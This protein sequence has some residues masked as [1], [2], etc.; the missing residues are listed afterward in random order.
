MGFTAAAGKFIVSLFVVVLVIPIAILGIDWVLRKGLP[1]EPTLTQYPGSNNSKELFV[2]LPGAQVSGTPLFVQLRLPLQ[3]RGDVLVVDYNPLKFNANT[4]VTHTLERM[5]LAYEKITFIGASMGGLV[6]YDCAQELHRRGDTRE[7]SFILLDTPTGTDDLAMGR[8]ARIV[9]HFP[10]GPFSN[11]FTRPVWEFGFIPSKIEDIHPRDIGQ[12]EML[13]NSYRT[14]PLSGYVDQLK[15]MTSHPSL[16]PVPEF[17][18]VFIQ[19]TRDEVVEVQA[20]ANWQRVFNDTP[21]LL[22]DSTHISF[23]DEPDRYEAAITQAL[24]LL[25]TN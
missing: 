24:E 1:D 17:R 10:F 2:L 3:Q 15:Y 25:G 19:S 16:Q 5:S 4:V 22:V 12:L 14:Y 11:L 21:L 6:A 18:V 9:G 20:Y 23:L 8:A 7:I 13:W